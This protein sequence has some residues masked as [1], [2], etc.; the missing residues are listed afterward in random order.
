MIVRP[1]STVWTRLLSFVLSLAV[2]AFAVAPALATTIQTDLWVYAQGDTVNVS[3]DGFGASEDV[4]IITTDPYG[5]V[6]D[7][8]IVASDLYGYIAYSFVLN[9]DVPGI[10][11]VVATGLS[12]G[13]SASTQF[14]PTV[15]LQLKGSDALVHTVSPGQGFGNVTQG[16]PLSFDAKADVASIANNTTVD[17][18]VSQIS[19][20]VASLTT[21]SGA[22][23]RGSGGAVSGSLAT[24]GVSVSTSALAI[25]TNYVVRLQETGTSTFTSNDPINAGDYY[26]NFTVVAPAKAPGS[27]TIDNIPISAVYGGSFTPTFTQL[28][29]G[30][31]SAASLTSGTCAISSGVVSFVGV[32]QCTL[33]A[34]VTE[35]T[36]YLA[37][38][39]SNQS[40]T[41]DQ[42]PVTVTV[43][44][45]QQKIYG[46]I[47]PLAF[48]YSITS[49]SL[50][51]GDTFSGALSRASGE[52]VGTYA[53]GQNTLTLGSN[54]DLSFF[55]EDFSINP[56][57][58][59]VTADNQA[60]FY[61]DANPPLTYTIS[62]FQN[63][64]TDAVVSGSADCSTTAVLAS[65]ISGNPYPITCTVGTLSA[66]NY[67][68]P[69]ANFVAGTLTI[70][71]AAYG[72]L[73]L[74]SAGHQILQ[75]IN[76][77]G[78]SVFKK[79]STVP[80]KFRVC[81]ANGNSIGT[82]G[83]VSSFRLIGTMTGTVLSTIDEAVDSTTPDT[84]FRWSATDQQWIYN[85][86][87]KGLQ[88]NKTYM[89][90]IKLND[91]TSITFIFG[92]K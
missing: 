13:L 1:V 45:G 82:A 90:E 41:I 70:Q 64:E 88:A 83:V 51:F 7:D 29:D 66:A 27:V 10:Y 63:G 34:S 53:I 38:I 18:T 17:W 8:G 23:S 24:V 52:D 89:Y 65:P 87:T 4:E 72:T 77:D 47:D 32:G 71:Y 74:G 5:V 33:Q 78:T 28:G 9:S 91:G 16:T 36:N 6:V 42:R 35:G 69:A 39:G 49:G 30:V 92:L 12:S 11:D 40:F 67:D 58:L 15:N 81:D 62:G 85:I 80:A 26:F 37:A 19:G 20:P 25:G 76:F 84:A 73:C 75:P 48:T 86:N 2:M 61:G 56:A 55:A 57:H 60:R 79:G 22:F 14:D 59:T 43:D 44:A 46:D 68:F 31:G 21:S 50:V 3:G 54:Y